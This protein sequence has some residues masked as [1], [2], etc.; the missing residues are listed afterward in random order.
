[1]LDK[2]ETSISFV[3]TD[4][5]LG[6]KH[7]EPKLLLGTAIV[8]LDVLEPSREFIRPQTKTPLILSMDKIQSLGC[9]VRDD[10]P[11]SYRLCR[12]L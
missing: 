6:T 2:D 4:G 5:C 10:K 1:M 8:A 11:S 9:D 12:L 7:G 3:I